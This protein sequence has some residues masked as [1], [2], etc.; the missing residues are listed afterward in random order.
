MN[1]TM[2]SHKAVS[3]KTLLFL[4]YTCDIS[5]DILLRSYYPCRK[6]RPILCAVHSVAAIET[7][8]PERGSRL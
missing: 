7:C 8:G 6:D 1:H 5:E 4:I 2:V 3:C